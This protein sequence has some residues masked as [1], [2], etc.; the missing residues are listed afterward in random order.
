LPFALNYLAFYPPHLIQ[1][2]VSIHQRHDAVRNLRNCSTFCLKQMRADSFQR[3]KTDPTF[4][5]E[6]KE[7]EQ[8][9]A[10]SIRFRIQ[11]D[12]V[13][14]PPCNVSLNRN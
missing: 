14:H 6:H 2:Y 1:K 8:A 10:F 4:K 12:K 3:A 13:L 9:T 7:Q 11:Q 5:S